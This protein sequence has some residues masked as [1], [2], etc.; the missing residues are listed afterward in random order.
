ML[1]LPEA[2]LYFF[3][4]SIV[5]FSFEFFYNLVGVLFGG[6]LSLEIL[7]LSEFFAEVFIFRSR[8][9]LFM[10]ESLPFRILVTLSIC[11]I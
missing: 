1:L 7:L 3:F 6:V 11:F 8:T 2:F 4:E 9:D 10:G 5:S